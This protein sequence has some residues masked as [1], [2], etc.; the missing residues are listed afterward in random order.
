[1]G[2]KHMHFSGLLD[3]ND[4]IADKQQHAERNVKY[5]CCIKSSVAKLSSSVNTNR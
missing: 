5:N 3:G 4:I 2:E 1:M